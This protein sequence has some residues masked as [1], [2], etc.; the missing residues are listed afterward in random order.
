MQDTWVQSLGQKDTLEKEMATHSSIL[1]WTENSM[2]REACGLQFMGLQRVRHNLATEHQQ[3]Q[4]RDIEGKQPSK[5][6]SPLDPRELI[7]R[8]VSPHLQTSTG[9]TAQAVMAAAGRMLQSGVEKSVQLDETNKGIACF[10]PIQSHI[11]QFSLTRSTASKGFDW[12]L[13]QSLHKPRA[14]DR[15]VGLKH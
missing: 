8:P 14:Q 15:K 6:T 7:P 11:L 4:K 10:A 9:L 2:D 5:S 3:Q 12:L 13:K 1:A